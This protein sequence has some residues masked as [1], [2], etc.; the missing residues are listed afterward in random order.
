[1][2][3]LAL[4]ILIG[5]SGSSDA[6]DT[7][8]DDAASDTATAV[9][10]SGAPVDDT[11]TTPPGDTDTPVADTGAAS[12]TS[13]PDAPPAESGAD[14]GTMTS[15]GCGKAGMAGVTNGTIKV[16]TLDR[17]YVLSIP[18]GYSSSKPYPLLFAWHGR[19]GSGTGFRSGGTSYGGGVEKASAGKAIFV[20]PNGLPVTSDPKDTGWVDRDPMGRDFAFFDAL[21]AD[22]SNRFCVDRARVFSYGHSFGGYMSNALACHRSAVIRGIAPVASGGPFGTCDGGAVAA[23]IANAKDD[24][25]VAYSQGTGTRDKW[26]AANGCDA[27]KTTPLIPAGC[28]AYGGCKPGEPVTFCGTE[29]GGHS[30]PT[31]VHEGIWS[32]FTA[33]P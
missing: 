32:F 18:A 33:L 2:R 5:C 17:T 11:G 20:Y 26:V 16:G 21:L 22:L 24:K 30:F 23:Y 15:A 28:V 25:T 9:D 12:E 14:S 31:Y 4:A 3:F 7:P 29:T 8:V 10:D 13:T 27:T 19:T 1:M 6:I